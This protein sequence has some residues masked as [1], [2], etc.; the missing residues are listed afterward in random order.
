MS[1]L[2]LI[3]KEGVIFDFA[4]EYS[5]LSGFIP[6]IKERLSFEYYTQYR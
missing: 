3:V 1:V 5:T 4:H 2:T 6:T